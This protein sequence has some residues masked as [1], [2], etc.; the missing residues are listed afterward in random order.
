MEL[1]KQIVDYIAKYHNIKAED[2]KS[3]RIIDTKPYGYTTP[4]KLLEIT[5]NNDR[6]IVINYNKILRRLNEY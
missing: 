6:I 2:V 3:Q 1:E 5:L 4:R